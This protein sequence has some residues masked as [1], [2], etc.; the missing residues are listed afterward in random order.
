MEVRIALALCV[1]IASTL[2]GRALAGAARRRAMLLGQLAEGLKLLRVHMVTLLEPARESLLQSEC[3]ALRAVGEAMQDGI[4]ADAAWQTVRKR[5]RRPGGA[6]DALS[7][8]DAQLLDRLFASLGVSG[9]EAQDLLIKGAIQT[10]EEMQLQARAGAAEAD[11]LYVAL[12]VLV[13][14]M[15]ALIVI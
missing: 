4:G 11:R 8:R 7:E 14:L 15:L 3:A 5:A 9:R 6:L 2:C 10:L 1:V 13:G 12:G